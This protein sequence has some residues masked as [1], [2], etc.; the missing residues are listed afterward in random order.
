[1]T[2]R[3][4]GGETPK[5][6]LRVP[7]VLLAALAAGLIIL[8]AQALRDPRARVPVVGSAASLRQLSESDAPQSARYELHGVASDQDAADTLALVRSSLGAWPDAIVLAFPTPTRADEVAE[9][10]QS[11]ESA[12]RVCEGSLAV[13]V[14]L[15]PDHTELPSDVDARMH[16]YFRRELC[17]SGRW[18]LCVDPRDH[19]DADALHAAISAAVVDALGRKATWR[20]STQSE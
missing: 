15:G 9:Y 17:N 20:A 10:G 18:L 1:M 3:T 19:A 5:R 7:W 4:E 13:P 16:A 12:V 2:E 6:R 8:V 14:L 11:L